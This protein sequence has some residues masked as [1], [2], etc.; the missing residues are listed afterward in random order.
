MKSEQETRKEQ[1]AMEAE[2]RQLLQGV[3]ELQRASDALMIAIALEFGKS[4]EGGELQVA[5]PPFDVDVLL[6][7]YT[8]KAERD[9]IEDRYIISVKRR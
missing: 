2:R 3:A 7:Q 5:L 8:C 4:K 1:K 6:K 9:G